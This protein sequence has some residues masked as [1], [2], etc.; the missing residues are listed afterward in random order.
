[1]RKYTYVSR[2]LQGDRV[3]AVAEAETRQGLLI[4]LKE[5]G[6]TVIEIKEFGEQGHKGK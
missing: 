4:Q 2:D 1:M 5:R 6:F 3:T